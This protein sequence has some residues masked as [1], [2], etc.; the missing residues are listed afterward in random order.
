MMD[1]SGFPNGVEATLLSNET[2]QID[3]SRIRLDVQRLALAQWATTDK[4]PT[5]QARILIVEAGALAVDLEGGKAEI[6]RGYGGQETLVAPPQEE[7]PHPGADPQAG[8]ASE[9]EEGVTP[10]P[11]P[12]VPPLTGTVAGLSMGDVAIITG[13]GAIELQ[14]VGEE[15]G[16]MLSISLASADAVKCADPVRG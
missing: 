13:E 6:G 10:N 15:P 2:I 4:W 16:T 1:A 8:T 9:I 3:A 12:P 7:S 11:T 14:G 5:E